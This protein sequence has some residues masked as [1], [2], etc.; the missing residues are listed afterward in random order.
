MAT[1]QIFR[2]RRGDFRFRLRAENGE[3]ILASEA[4]TTRAAAHMGVESVKR[5]APSDGN[6]RKLQAATGQCYFTLVAGNGEVVGVSE[7]Y[8]T[9][10]ARDR[11]IE[12]VKINAPAARL[13]ELT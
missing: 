3:T 8:S 12:S 2:D 1:F 4:Y 9:T 6:Y 5:N 11:G 13:E 10:H 7:V